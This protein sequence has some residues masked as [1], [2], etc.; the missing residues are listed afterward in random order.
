MFVS[1]E[2]EVDER[3]TGGA[4]QSVSQT[5]LLGRSLHCVDVLAPCVQALLAAEGAGNAEKAALAYQMVGVI[6]LLVKQ[7][8]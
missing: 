7:P 3:S 1:W 5:F 4:Q 6:C 2:V 8:V